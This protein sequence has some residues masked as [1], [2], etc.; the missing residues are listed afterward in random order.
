M[1]A[2]A[3]GNTGWNRVRFFLGLSSSAPRK[4]FPNGEFLSPAMVLVRIMVNC[5]KQGR[6][7][8]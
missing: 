1:D 7:V 2:E 5:G 8:A 3:A 6:I 4:R